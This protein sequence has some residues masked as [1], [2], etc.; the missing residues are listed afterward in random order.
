MS[1]TPNGNSKPETLEDYEAAEAYL[2]ALAEK[3]GWNFDQFLE[4]CDPDKLMNKPLGP[5][6]TCLS[7]ESI[8][9]YFSSGEKSPKTRDQQDIVDSIRRHIGECDSCRAN[10]AVWQSPQERK[11]E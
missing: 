3:A 8:E 5:T 7:G 4:D 10:T 9:L 11:K 6:E 1:K 2:R